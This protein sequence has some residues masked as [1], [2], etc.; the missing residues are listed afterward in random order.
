MLTQY[1]FDARTIVRKDQP[2]SPAPA[3]EHTCAQED[4]THLPSLFPSHFFT[5][6][7]LTP[8]AE[9]VSC[10]RYNMW[11]STG[12]LQTTEVRSL[13]SV[14]RPEVKVRVSA[15]SHLWGSPL[16]VPA[17]GRRLHPLA[18][19]HISLCYN[20][21]LPSFLQET[22]GRVSITCPLCLHF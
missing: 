15:G 12:W 18:L 14:Q 7:F 6:H 1:R 11:P 22:P 19:C 5:S 3:Q 21:P 16:L 9:L 17:P 2:T 10:G 8:Q 4:A 13:T 20:F